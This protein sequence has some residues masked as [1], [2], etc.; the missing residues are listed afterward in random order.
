[1][2]RIINIKGQKPGKIV[3]VLV[4]V[5]G[6]ERCGIEALEELLPGL[7]IESGEVYF[8]Y[9]NPRAIDVGTRFVDV[10]LNR[11]F[12]DEKDLTDIE[13]QSYER[14]RALEVMKYL[15]KSDVSLD[16]HSSAT[17]NSTP[18][19]ICEPHAEDIVSRLDFSIRSTGWDF[20]EPGGTDFYMNKIGKTGI[21]I[22]CGFH[23]DPEAKEL[24]KKAINDFLIINGLI[25]GVMPEKKNQSLVQLSSV[26]KT[27][28]NF[29]PV[30][31]FFDFE[32]L[33]AGELIGID[34]NEE[35]CAPNVDN[36]LILFCRV[37][38]GVGEE[39]FL[40]G[41]AKTV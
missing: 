33:R 32:P 16:V 13:R 29:T 27:K 6:N 4:G 8:I 22:E 23:E 11:M 39:A 26:Y 38:R 17:P 19:I 2:E 12:R 31:N 36:T 21:C 40:T 30:R 35:V 18:F 9:G 15:D 20:F 34:G 14:S 41:A 25:S 10:N 28:V 3:S 5:H 24:A 7:F 1:M 37:R